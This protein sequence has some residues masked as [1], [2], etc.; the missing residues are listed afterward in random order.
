MLLYNPELYEVKGDILSIKQPIRYERIYPNRH[1]KDVW[2]LVPGE[3]KIICSRHLENISLA[4]A[5]ASVQARA[6]CSWVEKYEN[7]KLTGGY[8]QCMNGFKYD[9]ILRCATKT[10]ADAFLN[11]YS[12]CI[13][14]TKLQLC[15]DKL[16]LTSHTDET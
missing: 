5:C 14:A 16:D 6:V 11:C 8:Y 12:T 1:R 7:E 9:L 2:E 4:Y 15:I 3:Y 13:A 10:L